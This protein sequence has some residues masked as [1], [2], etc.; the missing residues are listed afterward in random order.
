MHNKRRTRTEDE[1]R[2][3]EKELDAWKTKGSPQHVSPEKKKEDGNE[4]LTSWRYFHWSSATNPFDAASVTRNDAKMLDR[5]SSVESTPS[6]LFLPPPARP[7]ASLSNDVGLCK[8][9][10]LV[11]CNDTLSPSLLSV[12]GYEGS[13]CKVGGLRRFPP[14]SLSLSRPLPPRTNVEGWL[15][16]VYI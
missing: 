7:R 10:T 15:G 1:S 13:S 8:G 14:P 16:R 4:R 2:W 6:I 9:E 3:L 11:R 12:C 5:F